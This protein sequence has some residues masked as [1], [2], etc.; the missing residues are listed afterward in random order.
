MTQLRRAR[1]DDKRAYDR[2]RELKETIKGERD[3]LKQ[4]VWD[5]ERELV[6]FKEQLSAKDEEIGRLRMQ[7]KGPVCLIVHEIH[8]DAH[9][10]HYK[11]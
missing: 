8:R 6:R 2:L 7:S 1:A 4:K 11:G 9:C 10:A 3:G 5:R